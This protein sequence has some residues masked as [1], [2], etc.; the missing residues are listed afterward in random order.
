[1]MN[2]SL[3][4][5][6][7]SLALALGCAP[8]S[9]ENEKAPSGDSHYYMY[10]PEALVNGCFYKGQFYSEGA[11]VKTDANARK[12]CIYDD[13]VKPPRYHWAVPSWGE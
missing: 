3:P 6:A 1:M 9:A 2:L 11:T 8:A 13:K 10:P 5:I 4:T 7:L 12:K